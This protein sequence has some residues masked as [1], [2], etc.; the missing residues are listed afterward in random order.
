MIKLTNHNKYIKSKPNKF[1]YS[2]LQEIFF[3]TAVLILRTTLLYQ[4][5][6]TPLEILTNY[7]LDPK[8]MKL[9][10]M[11]LPSIPID[12]LNDSEILKRFIKRL[13]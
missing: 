2:I 11:A 3:S 9:N 7:N 8:K 12:T 1:F 4:F 5:A 13:V 6:I 10:S